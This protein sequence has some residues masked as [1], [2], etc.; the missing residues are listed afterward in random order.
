MNAA[1]PTAFSRLVQPLRSYWLVWIIAAGILANGV[2]EVL[3]G[4][5]SGPRG[6]HREAFG[7]PFGISAWN[8]TA[9]VVLG[10]TLIFFSFHLLR[11][12][13]L[14]WWLAVTALAITAALHIIWSHHVVLAL[15]SAVMLVL[16]LLAR[17]R[18]TVH[19]EPR[20]I[21]SGL[22]LMAITIIVAMILGSVAFYVLDER[23]FGQEFGFAQAMMLTLRQFFGVGNP[24]LLPRTEFARWFPRLVTLLGVTAEAL[25]LFAFF[26]PVA[27]RLGTAPQERRRARRLI[28]TYGRSTYDYFKVWNDKSLFFPSS[29][30][31][32]GYRVLHNVAVA[33][34]DP[35]A[36]VERLPEA[37]RE[38]VR[39]SRDNGWV[40]TFLMPDE[41]SVYRQLQLW[42][43]KIGEEATVD[44]D[45]FAR[46]TANDKYFRRVR[47]QMEEKGAVFSRHVPPH[48]RALLGEV[49][50][51]SAKWIDQAHYREF[52]FVQGTMSRAYL[53]ATVLDVLRDADGQVI[54]FVNE[55]P[56]HAAG[57]AS[58]DM[59]RRLPEAHWATMDYL[60]LRIMLALREEGYSRFNLGLAPFA[61]V[62]EDPDSAL[63]E[64]TMRALAPYAQRLAHT[65]G[66]SQYKKKFDPEWRDRLV[67]Y[68]GGPLVLPR[69]ALALF[70]VV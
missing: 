20:G 13:R 43:V 51:L 7:L 59:M 58:F 38:F 21:V 31:F 11:R 70:T 2:L 69:V 10:F 36:P 47:R 3:D 23:E 32:V 8:R 9:T 54:A 19:F 22:R 4:L 55:V 29:D 37:A 57:E 50:R 17:K 61:G 48:A 67:V 66:I 14:A 15:G 63:L 16:L 28:G 12:R 52:G 49:E 60:F 53:Q 56:S 1:E 33:L 6:F 62:G 65:E 24:G 46:V 64:K 30:A 34:G 42:Q 45:R 5:R 68:D 41:P 40:A 44:L 39:F 25:A 27:Y 18:Y 26:R 35:V